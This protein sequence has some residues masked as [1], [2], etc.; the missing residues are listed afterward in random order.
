[1]F[2][3]KGLQKSTKLLCLR[4]CAG[5]WIIIYDEYRAL[6]SFEHFRRFKVTSGIRTAREKKTLDELKEKTNRTS[7]RVLHSQIAGS[8][9][10][11]LRLQASVLDQLFDRAPSGRIALQ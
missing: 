6:Q 9:H 8:C 7:F 3:G 11:A 2:N 5:L 4:Y 10:C 1:M